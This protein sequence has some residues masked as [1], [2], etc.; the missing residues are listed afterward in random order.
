MKGNE[1]FCKSNCRKAEHG[2]KGLQ[3]KKYASKKLSR[4]KLA[5]NWIGTPASGACCACAVGAASVARSPPTFRCLKPW[6][7]S[8]S[9]RVRISVLASPSCALSCS[10]SDLGVTPV[11][12]DLRLVGEPSEADCGV[13]G[14]PFALS[15]S[16]VSELAAPRSIDFSDW[17][18][19]P[20]AKIGVTP[21]AL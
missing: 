2:M 10:T 4:H 12:G 9:F 8:L 20:A 19:A 14:L 7:E 5:T 17:A 11:T 18:G 1:Y 16:V 15:V 13:K 6:S 21:F 3:K